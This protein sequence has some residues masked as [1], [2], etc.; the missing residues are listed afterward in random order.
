[1]SSIKGENTVGQAWRMEWGMGQVWRKAW[2]IGKAWRM[3][4]AEGVVDGAGMVDGEV[5]QYRQNT[6]H[7]KCTH[8]LQ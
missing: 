8:F 6:Y 1:M 4:Q 2:Q 7:D 5:G 3:G